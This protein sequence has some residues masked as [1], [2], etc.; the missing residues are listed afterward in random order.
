[1]PGSAAGLAVGAADRICDRRAVPSEAV[2]V[3]ERVDQSLAHLGNAAPAGASRRLVRIGGTF[4]D[5]SGIDG[6]I[7]RRAAVTQPR[8][9]S[10]AAVESASPPSATRACSAA[11]LASSTTSGSLASLGSGP[12][13]RPPW[14]AVARH[15]QACRLRR[16]GRGHRQRTHRRQSCRPSAR[17]RRECGPRGGV[18]ATETT[19]RPLRGRIENVT[20]VS[21][22][23][24]PSGSRRRRA[25]ASVAALWVAPIRPSSARRFASSAYF[26]RGARF[27][28]AGCL[29]LAVSVVRRQ[30][31]A[32]RPRKKQP[33]GGRRGAWRMRRAPCERGQPFVLS[34]PT[35]GADGSSLSQR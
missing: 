27:T 25:A 17:A 32:S 22:F 23:H 35:T 4:V 24:R 7:P 28:C 26:A 31:G 12:A 16:V 2:A 14:P 19:G 6:H 21:W 30:P 15:R 34:S 33:V 20:R 18:R 29:Q 10:H 8:V 9:F 5:D 13:S 1:M 11:S 3:D